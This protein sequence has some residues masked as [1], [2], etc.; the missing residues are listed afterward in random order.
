M[1]WKSLYHEDLALVPSR[2][3]G[4]VRQKDSRNSSKPPSSD[5]FG[6]RTQSLRPQGKRHDLEGYEQRKMK[7]FIFRDSG[8]RGFSVFRDFGHVMTQLG[9]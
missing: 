2:E 7:P 4:Q 3:N 6:K 8:N 9:R 5:G 1:P